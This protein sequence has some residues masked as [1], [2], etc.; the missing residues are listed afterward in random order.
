MPRAGPFPFPDFPSHP[1][2]TA[3]YGQDTGRN[4]E[5]DRLSDWTIHALER[6]GREDEIIPVCIAEANQTDSFD[7]LVKRLIAMHRF[8]EAE[9]WIRKGIQATKGKWSG[10][11]AGL[12]G[13]LRD[14]GKVGKLFERVKGIAQP[15]TPSVRDSGWPGRKGDRKKEAVTIMSSITKLNLN[16]P[17]PREHNSPQTQKAQ[18][19]QRQDG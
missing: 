2:L 12:R 19:H 8:E 4:F 3:R 18:R 16:L 15:Q 11:A 13:K 14:I 9:H 1:D 6:A 10:I 17:V 7:R 5:R